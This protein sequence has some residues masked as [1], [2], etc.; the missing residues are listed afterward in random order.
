MALSGTGDKGQRRNMYNHEIR[1]LYKEKELTRNIRLRRV[2]WVSHVCDEDEGR[3]GAEE[4]TER[5]NRM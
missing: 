4:S 3:K 1:N 2:Q 5:I